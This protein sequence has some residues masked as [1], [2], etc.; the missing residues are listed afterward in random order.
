M[1]RGLKASA[2]AALTKIVGSSGTPKAV[3]WA[4]HIKNA[5]VRSRYFSMSADIQGGYLDGF[6]AAIR[7]VMTLERF[8][9]ISGL[10]GIAE[11]YD[12]YLMDGPEF[13]A[14]LV[15]YVVKYADMLK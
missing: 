5:L 2:G 13:V 12:T 6:F 4:G 11:Q 8:V 15:Y 9:K 1:G 14:D 7:G 3:D 10:R